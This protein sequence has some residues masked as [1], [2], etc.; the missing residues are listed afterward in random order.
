MT[1]TQAD[2]AEK[3][4]SELIVN[5][6]LL[7]EAEKF[8][9][10]NDRVVFWSKILKSDSTIDLENIVRI[11]LLLSH[12]NAMIKKVRNSHKIYTAVQNEKQKKQSEGQKKIVEKKQNT[13]SLKQVVA[14][15]KAKVDELKEIINTY[16][17]D[18]Y[19]LHN[20][21]KK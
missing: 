21:L 11:V 1:T 2:K 7:A 13:L 19:E 15:T 16:N 18:I 3:Q 9:I 10:N 17:K 8:D 4:Y 14:A 12:G 20:K 6:D 5:K